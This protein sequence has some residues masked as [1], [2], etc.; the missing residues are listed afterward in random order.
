MVEV[1]STLVAEVG[2]APD[3][4]R[5]HIARL[6]SG[7]LA[8]PPCANALPGLLSDPEQEPNVLARM[9]RISQFA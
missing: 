7:L 8:L 3:D 1:R 4:V 6:V 5:R 2:A 9:G